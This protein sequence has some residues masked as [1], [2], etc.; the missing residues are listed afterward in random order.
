MGDMIKIIVFY[1]YQNIVRKYR[2]FQKKI[3]MYVIRLN[4]D[5]ELMNSKP[6]HNCLNVMRIFGIKNIYYSVD[7]GEL[8]KEK[9]SELETDHY[10][11]A[12]R[13]YMRAINNVE[14]LSLLFNKNSKTSVIE[15]DK[16]ND[17]MI[18]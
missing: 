3:D 6:C 15:I 10:S 16:I 14:L 5:D 1:V 12:H 18:K 13:N 8:K 2:A 4:N 9:I 17:K 11:I 7:G